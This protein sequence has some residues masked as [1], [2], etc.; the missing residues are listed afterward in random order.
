MAVRHNKRDKFE[1]MREDAIE[2]IL[3]AAKE[4][5]AN[6]GYAAT[7]VQ[8]IAQKANLVP[9]AIYH[10]FAGKEDL[11]EAVLDRE[12]A[13]I[14]KTINIGLQQ[15]LLE[16]GTDAFLDFMAKSVY[17]NKERISLMCHL[18]QFRNAT[19][20]C[21]DKL[22]LIHHF[23]EI[24]GDYIRGSEA[25]EAMQ[26]IIIDF[27]CSAAFYSITGR[28]DIFERQISQLK[29]KANNLLMGKLLDPSQI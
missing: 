12:M 23:S 3:S 11:L 2:R 24:I 7:T 27:V 5:F 10:Y 21:K 25:R 1:Q 26:D 13:E 8:M 20:Y 18:V 16:D 6:N 4:L 28:R 14:D 9:S 22:H 17:E 15:Y 19:E 29:I